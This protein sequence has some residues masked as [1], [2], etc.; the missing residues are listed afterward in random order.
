[1]R[2]LEG[3]LQ[4]VS[5]WLQR[6]QEV[7]REPTWKQT[8]E[9]RGQRSGV[10]RGRAPRTQLLSA[11][12]Q[13]GGVLVQ[14]LVEVDAQL[15]QL[16]LDAFDLLLQR[17]S[18]QSPAPPPCSSGGEAKGHLLD[19]RGQVE[20]VPPAQLEQPLQV[21]SGF[22]VQAAAVQPLLQTDARSQRLLLLLLLRL[23]LLTSRAT[24]LR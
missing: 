5:V 24:I 20:A 19:L 23:L 14:V 9:V 21:A 1:M 2:I 6:A 7:L 17:R 12:G 11:E 13:A 16:L 10:G 4:L 3:D 18:G 15:A 8:A 22:W